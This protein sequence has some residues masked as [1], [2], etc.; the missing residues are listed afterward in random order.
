MYTKPVTPG[1]HVKRNHFLRRVI[2]AKRKSKSVGAVTAEM[3][4][5]MASRV[6]VYVCCL[7]CLL[8]AV[9]DSAVGIATRYGL[10]GPGIESR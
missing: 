2:E 10:G 5:Q 3:F 7:V 8:T 9:L 4:Q 1:S 6:T